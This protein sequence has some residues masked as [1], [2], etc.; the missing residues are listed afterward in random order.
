MIYEWLSAVLDSENGVLKRLYSSDAMIE[1]LVN[2]FGSSKWV[3]D[4]TRESM[5]QDAK[6]Y[7]RSEE[8]KRLERLTSRRLARKLSS[9]K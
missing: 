8:R 9:K 2:C 1:G 5:V 3:S 7:L 4:I 6:V